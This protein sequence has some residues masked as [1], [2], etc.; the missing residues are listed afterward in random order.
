V[1]A[2]ITLKADYDRIGLIKT[3]FSNTFAKA[4]TTASA[5]T[6]H[7]VGTKGY[8]VDAVKE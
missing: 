5:L 2:S 1:D 4:S 6:N 7:L 3:I 8:I